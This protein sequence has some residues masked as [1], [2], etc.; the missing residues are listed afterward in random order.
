MKHTHLSLFGTIFLIL[1]GCVSKSEK[2]PTSPLEVLNGEKYEPSNSSVKL[3]G[4]PISGLQVKRKNSATKITG[5]VSEQRPAPGGLKPVKFL[6]LYLK[7]GNSEFKS[8]TDELGVFTFSDS[9]EDGNY[10]LIVPQCLNSKKSIAVSGYD[11]KLEDWVIS[12]KK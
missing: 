10:E 2:P 4:L 9:I 5:K 7:G 11:I 8:V 1:S 12:C 3:G 6:A